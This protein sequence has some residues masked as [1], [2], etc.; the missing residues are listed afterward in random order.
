MAIDIT[1]TSYLVAES[2]RGPFRRGNKRT[3]YQVIYQ[4]HKT[5]IF[6]RDWSFEIR[7]YDHGYLSITY[8]K[9]SIFQKIK[10]LSVATILIGL[11]LFFLIYNALTIGF[12]VFAW[13]VL[14]AI[15]DAI[16]GLSEQAKGDLFWITTV[17]TIL[18]LCF[19]AFWSWIK[20][21]F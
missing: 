17:L 9:E 21:D 15:L 20:K 2:Y 8:E 16:F 12:I 14:S 18:Y 19:L 1:F 11:V 13:T 10:G 6:A 4:E 5:G 3:D 7:L